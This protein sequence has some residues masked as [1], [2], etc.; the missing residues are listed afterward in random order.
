MKVEIHSKFF[1]QN[2]VLGHISLAIG[3]GEVVALTGPSG[4]GKSTFVRMLCGLDKRYQGQITD[5]GRVG[6]VFQEPTL[7]PWRSLIDNI[8]L[9]TGCDAWAA[10]TAL[11]QVELGDRSSDYPNQLSLGQQRRVGL[12]RALAAKPQ[13]L[14]LDE[15]FASLDEATAAR[16]RTLTR[17]ILDGTGFSTVLVTHNLE[18]A[19]ELADRVLVL[20][21]TPAEITLDYT[22]T[23]NIS[24]YPAE[25][26]LLRS[27]LNQSTSS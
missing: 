27:R 18:E 24:D 2:Q 12:A 16:M 4:I 9:V 8:T 6:F 10:Q 19:V 3:K 11:D 15:A 17:H 25:A 20:D 7:L 1:G 13:T 5:V 23:A 22:V 21:G 26:A 14:V